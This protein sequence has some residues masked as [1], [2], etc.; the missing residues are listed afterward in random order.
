MSAMGKLKKAGS[1]GLL[2]VLA[3]GL[4]CT[5]SEDV[6][7]AQAPSLNQYRYHYVSLSAALPEGFDF[8]DA[9]RINDNGDIFFTAYK[10]NDVTCLPTVARYANG[11]TSLLHEGFANAAN[12]RGTLGGGV[13]LDPIQGTTQ[14]ALFD[15]RSVIPIPPLPGQLAS[16]VLRLTD[17][18]IALVEAIVQLAPDEF[19]Y[20]VYLYRN[21]RATALDFAG[22]A[23]FLLDVNNVGVISGTTFL[24]D[25]GRYRAFRLFPGSAMTLLDP[26]STEPHA[27]SQEIN[28]SGDVL[29]W[30]FIFGGRERV[31]IWRDRTFHTFFTE[32]TQEFPTVSNALHWN[33][34]GLIVITSAGAFSYIVPEV[35]V[36]LNLADITNDELVPLRFIYDVNNRGDM[37]GIGFRFT[38]DFLADNFL[39]QRVGPDAGNPLP[40]A[41]STPRAG[42]GS[43]GSPIWFG[44]LS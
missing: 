43:L 18:G 22:N 25:I 44:R 7:N 1:R 21:G 33:D 29:G 10:C 17:S 37:V 39:L 4:G 6:A 38:P 28:S 24:P 20:K 27:W 3:V 31:G 32:G 41:A 26:L 34:Q 35:G 9:L 13:V 12:A 36:R 30:S 42:C 5:L 19:Q 2:A 40:I 23:A 8:I 11:A 15:G 16:D 14:A